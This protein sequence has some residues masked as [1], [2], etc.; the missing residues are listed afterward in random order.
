MADIHT[1][2][3]TDSSTIHQFGYDEDTAELVV[4]FKN[5]QEYTYSEVEMD[6]FESMADL[7]D[8]PTKGSVGK[9]FA[10]NIRSK[11]YPFKKTEPG[12]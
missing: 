12:A 3:Q 5:G 7:S 4:R 11:G 10:K 6:V 8:D 9:F 1:W 2:Y